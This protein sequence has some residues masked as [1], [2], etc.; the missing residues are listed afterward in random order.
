MCDRFEMPSFPQFRSMWV[1]KPGS[2]LAVWNSAPFAVRISHLFPWPLGKLF[3]CFFLYFD[4]CTRC[5]TEPAV[6]SL[7]QTTTKHLHYQCKYATKSQTQLY[8]HSH[9]QPQKNEK[10]MLKTSK[11]VPAFQK[12]IY[13]HCWF[14]LLYSQSVK[15]KH[16]VTTSI[17]HNNYITPLS[18]CHKL[19]N[20]PITKPD[21]Y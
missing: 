7:L 10:D 1:I 3:C 2:V 12:V 21:P 9:V 14:C 13:K 4:K 6:C 19:I 8:V 17:R 18:N 5:G 16:R 20:F 11:Q 15:Q